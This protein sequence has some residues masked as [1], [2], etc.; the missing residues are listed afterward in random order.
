[1]TQVR[2]EGVDQNQ[3]AALTLAGAPAA[4]RVPKCPQG[5]T[6]AAG[7]G[8]SEV[9][10]KSEHSLL[11]S[12]LWEGN[13]KEVEKN[14]HGEKHLC[15]GECRLWGMTEKGSRGMFCFMN[16][17]MGPWSAR[18]YRAYGFL[19]PEY[20]TIILKQ[21]TKQINPTDCTGLLDPEL[22]LRR[23]SASG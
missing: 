17:M 4:S 18:W 15:Q 11:R 22:V 21:K 14:A 8:A 2:W 5:P 19:C 7:T 6:E 16:H 12:P 9:L 13:F 10:W 3:D 1:M 23:K 20:F